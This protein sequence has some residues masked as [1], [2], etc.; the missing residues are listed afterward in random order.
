MIFS[1]DSG[2]AAGKIFVPASSFRLLDLTANL[3]PEKDDSFVIAEGTI[4]YVKRESGS[5]PTSGSIYLEYVY[6][7]I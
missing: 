4:I 1:D 6:G 7:N 2:V 3:V 5:V